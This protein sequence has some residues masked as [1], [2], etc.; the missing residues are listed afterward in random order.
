MWK[1][2][3]ET[4]HILR[5]EGSLG[6]K[7]W[8][9]RRVNKA[10][11]PRSRSSHYWTCHYRHPNSLQNAPC[12]YKSNMLKP[13]SHWDITLK[14]KLPSKCWGNTDIPHELYCHIYQCDFLHRLE[15]VS[16]NPT[17]SIYLV[18]SHL[19]SCIEMQCTCK[20]T[21]CKLKS[22]AMRDDVTGI[23]WHNNVRYDSLNCFWQNIY[24]NMAIH[25]SGVTCHHP[26]VKK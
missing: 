16:S 24:D 18:L 6:L 12:S 17:Q 26:A 22:H 9:I 20:G 2:G 23:T 10:Q 25:S 14:P 7:T 11:P 13:A 3:G 1:A 21:T 19:M 8:L 5:W 15:A 4:R